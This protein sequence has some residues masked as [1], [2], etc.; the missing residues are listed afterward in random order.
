MYGVL[1]QGA[2]CPS[3][4]GVGRDVVDDQP[5]AFRF[6][7]LLNNASDALVWPKQIGRLERALRDQAA[8]DPIPLL[9]LGQ[10]DPTLLGL[11]ATERYELRPA[12]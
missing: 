4:P 10:D 2:A 5:L 9:W 7:E 1:D 3:R 12:P 8:A 6:A 11:S